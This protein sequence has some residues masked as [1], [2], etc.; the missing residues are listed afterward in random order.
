MS[1]EDRPHAA[2][3]PRFWPRWLI[4]LA[5]VLAAIG[6]AVT[7]VVVT[8]LSGALPGSPSASAAGIPRY[9]VEISFQ[10]VGPKGGL[11]QN[12]YLVDT[13]T[14]KHLGTYSPAPDAMFNYV[15]GSADDT[16]FVLQ[17]IAGPNYG[18]LGSKF[19]NGEYTTGI[20][21]HRLLYLLRVTPGAARLAQ[22]TLLPIAPSP[23][24]NGGTSGLGALDGMAVS[25]DGRTLAVALGPALQTYSIATG[26]LLRTWTGQQDKSPSGLTWLND[27]RTLAFTDASGDGSG[28]G[29]IY[30]LN[31]ASPGTS[32]T[33]DSRA[34]FS[35]PPDR[36]CGSM[37]MTADGKAVICGSSQMSGCTDGVLNLAAYSVSTG[38]LERVIYRFP[39]QCTF[40]LAVPQWA[41]SSTLA[42][43]ELVYTSTAPSHPQLLEV[44]GVIPPGR[45]ASLPP[46]LGETY[47]GPGTIA[48]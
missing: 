36:V 27:D 11:V 33:A 12:A 18:P 42:I 46:G 37:L 32:L 29:T 41:A 34:A 38:K 24:K 2:R 1:V 21:E 28:S 39:G 6:L 22:L 16:T 14:G 8:G 31:T 10:S 45:S 3:R 26:Q 4:A 9:E 23:V 5:A 15:A 25:P 19:T 7:L 43:A 35:M 48:F 17:A 30:T 44:V 20:P 47:G 13:S 40:G